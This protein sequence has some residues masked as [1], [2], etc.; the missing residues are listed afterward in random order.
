MGFGVEFEHLL[1]LGILITNFAPNCGF[2]NPTKVYFIKFFQSQGLESSPKNT[3][4]DT[5][6][7]RCKLTNGTWDFVLWRCLIYLSI[8]QQ[9]LIY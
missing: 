6:I 5:C 2:D 3:N 4:I 9:E 8:I 1:C 7:T